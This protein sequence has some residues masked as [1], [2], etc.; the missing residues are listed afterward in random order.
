MTLYKKAR[1]KPK[2]SHSWLFLRVMWHLKKTIR[3]YHI[4]FIT[5]LDL[6]DGECH[7]QFNISHC[8]QQC[9]RPWESSE[10]RKDLPP[11]DL[12]PPLYFSKRAHESGAGTG[13]HSKDL[14]PRPE[15]WLQESSKLLGQGDF[16]LKCGPLNFIWICLFLFHFEANTSA[17]EGE[18][19]MKLRAFQ[20]CDLG[21]AAA[22]AMRRRPSLNSSC[23]ISSKMGPCRLK[24]LLAR[25]THEP[26]RRV[27]L[28]NVGRKGEMLLGVKVRL[29]PLWLDLPS[30]PPLWNWKWFSSGGGSPI[31]PAVRAR[32]SSYS[33]LT[34]FPDPF[35]PSHSQ[36]GNHI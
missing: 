23:W 17:K 24:L 18:R 9:T 19:L 10:G 13:I 16:S 6:E 5:C 3:T 15:I 2:L 31:P 32:E 7:I 1:V 20:T 4:T 21:A 33:S 34:R 28:F 25:R 22:H 26:P 36:W 30:H 8:E 12:S 35:R 29:R 27:P 11:A 14:Y